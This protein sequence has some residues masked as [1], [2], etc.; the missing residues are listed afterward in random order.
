MPALPRCEVTYKRSCSRPVAVPDVRQYVDDS[1]KLLDTPHP[2]FFHESTI[3]SRCKDPLTMTLVTGPL[4]T[5]NDGRWTGPVPVCVRASTS[6]SLPALRT[7]LHQFMANGTLLIYPGVGQLNV[8]CIVSSGYP[9]LE[10][11]HSQQWTPGGQGKKK[12]G[13]PAEGHSGTYTCKK[14]GWPTAFHR[15]MIQVRAVS[16]SEPSP[17]LNGRRIG[18]DFRLTESVS[19]ECNEGY[20]LIGERTIKCNLGEWLGEIP[21]CRARDCPEINMANLDSNLRLTINGGNSPGSV[22]MFTCQSGFHRVGETRLTCQGGSW[23][24]PF[25][26]CEADV[27]D[28]TGPLF[29]PDDCNCEVWERCVAN[30]NGPSTCHCIHPR[31]CDDV[32]QEQYCGSDGRTY[33][34]ICRMKAAGCLLDLDIQVVSNGPCPEITEPPV[35]AATCPTP[36]V[37][38]ALIYHRGQNIATA[39]FEIIFGNRDEIEVRCN[40]DFTVNGREAVTATCWNGAWTPALPR[41]EVTYKRSCSRPV[42]VPDVR[43][44]VDDSIKLLD[45]P[46]PSFFHESTIMSRC[47]DPL[48]MTLVTGPLRTCNDGRWTG[49]VPVCERALTSFSLPALDTTL[50]QFMAN[51]TL[52][53]Y[54]GVGQLNV[55]CIV[56]SGYPVLE[57]SHSQQWTPG[58]QGKKKYG[59]PAEGHSGTYTCKKFGWPTAFH[60]LMIQVRAVSCPE[61]R[62]P[63]NGRRIGDDFRL[64]KSV[65]FE[66]NEGFDLIGER[67]I[68]CNLGE[69]LGEIPRCR[70]RDCPEINM[71][72]LDPN[73]HLTINGGNSPGS[74]VIF[75]CQSGFHRV[76]ETR[77]ACQG[78]SWSPSFPT[79]EADVPDDTGPL[80]GPDDCNCEVWERCV[81]N[82]NGPSTCHCIHPRQCHDVDQEQYCGSDGRTY[83]SICRMKAAGCLLDLDIQVV[84]NGPCRENDCNCEVWERCVANRN[85]PS[86]C[87]CIH[88][89][90]CDDVGQEQ[91]CGSDGRTYPSI[92]RMK[93][94]GCLMD[95]DIQVVSSGP[96]PESP[97][98]QLPTE[99]S[100][101]SD[102]SSESS[103]S[104][105]D[106]T[107]SPSMET[108]ESRNSENGTTESE[109]NHADVPGGTGPL[110]GPNDCNCEVWER[111][112]ANSNGPSTCHCI[113]PRQCDGAVGQEQYCGSDGRTY[114]SI[115]RMKAAGCLLD[116]DIQVV[117]NGT[118][119]ENDYA[120]CGYSEYAEQR[121]F[122]RISGGTDAAEGQWPWQVALFCHRNCTRCEP[123]FFCGGSLI[124]RNWVLSAAHCFRDNH[125]PWSAIR[126]YTGIRNK[127]RS[128]LRLL[129]PALVYTLDGDDAL[130]KHEAFNSD[131]D[132]DIAVLRLSRDVMLSSG[133]RPI[134]MPKLAMKERALYSPHGEPPYVAGWGTTQPYDYGDLCLDGYRPVTSSLLQYLVI[135]VRTDRECRDSFINHYECTSVSFYKP[136]IAF[137][138]GVPEGGLDACKGDS[139]GPV[140]RQMTVADGSK[141]WVQIGIVSWGEGCA[142]EGRYGI[143]TRLSAYTDWIESHTATRDSRSG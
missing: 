138:A 120:A 127:S 46:H 123:R 140:M 91:Y 112:V 37:P 11:S 87:H 9:V 4:R 58:G 54:P 88:P 142:V 42:A 12:Y 106:P 69:W 78:G 93:A 62:P 73:L 136:A 122:G 34:S 52:L 25:P 84:S 10:H 124:A 129:D 110:L 20:D 107:G 63:L 92:C 68:K 40:T 16:C 94:A 65:L 8:D 134:C 26:T 1:I 71:A 90:Q 30:S 115:C 101:L 49:P 100:L 45:T 31:Q 105:V 14:F 19:F 139:G 17:P 114:P 22:V 47:K 135:P 21:R 132:N 143:Y 48:T 89:Q 97:S 85:G 74:V 109:T 5:C 108:T 128:A 130:I 60:R 126:V 33:P 38:N 82:S 6:F 133:I 53:I 121:I 86:T 99:D 117:S 116:L 98:L 104:P 81:A 44:Y 131:L 118:C 36:S 76:G 2:S 35:A 43:Q 50:H 113:H 119:P 51:G 55:D 18:D 57:H 137:C 75:T 64:T 13:V 61:P 27:P 66:C 15:L 70:A 95:L 83:A 96:C 102:Y 56:S 7:T 79:C 103:E 77:L 29:G 72:H 80:L 59:V 39:G 67:T 24:P 32:G 125:C 111:C 28:D 141:R 41:C 3:M 23:S